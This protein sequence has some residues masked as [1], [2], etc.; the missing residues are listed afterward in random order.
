MKETMTRLGC[1]TR[2]GMQSF[3]NAWQRLSIILL[4]MVLTTVTAWAETETVSY[5]DADGNHQS[6]T[7][8]ILTGSEEPNNWGEIELARG[9]YVVKRN[10]SYTNAIADTGSGS[11]GIN[12]I[13]ADGAEM[14]ISVSSSL[15]S[16]SM[17]ASSVPPP[18]LIT[19]TS[20]AEA[21]SPSMADR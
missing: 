9:W 7:A 21:T 14:S 18:A 5:I 4:M 12:I 8:T 2:L 19:A 15:T 20:I 3:K 1:P 17:A 16:P 10:I 6:V 11:G 13:L